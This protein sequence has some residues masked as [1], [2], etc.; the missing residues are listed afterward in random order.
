M[1]AKRMNRSVGEVDQH[2]HASFRGS[3]EA[4][5]R[6]GEFEILDRKPKLGET[7]RS[8]PSLEVPHIYGTVHPACS[9]GVAG[10]KRG[11]R[12]Q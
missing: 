6:W 9:E 10:S 7:L 3:R 2:R 5:A 8:A 1:S 12:D 11:P 4:F